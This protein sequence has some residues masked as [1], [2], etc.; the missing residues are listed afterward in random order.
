MYL[1]SLFFYF[2]VMN[3]CNKRQILCYLIKNIPRK[4]SDFVYTVT[5][6]PLYPPFPSYNL[7]KPTVSS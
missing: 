6:N 7:L 1:I 3:Q 2:F 4:W 5:G